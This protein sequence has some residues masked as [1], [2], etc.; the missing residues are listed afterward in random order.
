MIICPHCYGQVIKLDGEPNYY[1]CLYCLY[2]VER[3]TLE[4]PYVFKVPNQISD[5]VDG[6]GFDTA[7]LDNWEANVRLIDRDQIEGMIVFM[8]G[9]LTNWL[10]LRRANRTN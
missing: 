8:T 3:A 6:N 7:W 9:Y 4:Q 2:N 10:Q 5:W 1:K